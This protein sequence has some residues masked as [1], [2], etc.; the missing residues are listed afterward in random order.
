[1]LVG[2]RVEADCVEAQAARVRISPA[3]SR[4]P[5]MV[6]ALLSMAVWTSPLGIGHTGKSNEILL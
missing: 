2:V 6:L 4:D 1:M 5:G 3:R